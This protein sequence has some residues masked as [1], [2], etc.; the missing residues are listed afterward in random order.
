VSFFKDCIHVDGQL[1]QEFKTFAYCTSRADH[2]VFDLL[3]EK[4][5]DR[6]S[7]DVVEVILEQSRQHYMEMIFPSKNFGSYIFDG[8]EICYY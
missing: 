2:T 5:A 4:L 3:Q 8:R 6:I 1:G 7:D